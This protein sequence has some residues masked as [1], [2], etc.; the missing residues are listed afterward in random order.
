MTNPK[1]INPIE[2]IHHELGRIRRD[3]DALSE[4]VASEI[5]KDHPAKPKSTKIV[6]PRTNKLFKT[7][8]RRH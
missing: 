2:Q 4:F 6:D 5:E 3:L 8:N 1:R 7:K